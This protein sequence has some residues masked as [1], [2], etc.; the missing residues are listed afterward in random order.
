[1]PLGIVVFAVLSLAAIVAARMGVY[2][3]NRREYVRAYRQPGAMRVESWQHGRLS[4]KPK[5]TKGGT[6]GDL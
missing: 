3:G 1:M 5:N 6:D 2:V 4:R